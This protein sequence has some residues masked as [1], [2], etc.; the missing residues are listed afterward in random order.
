MHITFSD[1]Y[2][3]FKINAS[4]LKFKVVVEHYLDFVDFHL[5]YLEHLD[6]DPFADEC[7]P[8]IQ[9][10]QYSFALQADV[11]CNNNKKN[12]YIVNNLIQS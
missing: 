9:D 4:Y 6:P 10:F 5:D 1:K 2:V 3:Y 12:K 7:W 8:L 11:H